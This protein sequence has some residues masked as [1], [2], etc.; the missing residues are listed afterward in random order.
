MVTVPKS[1]LSKPAIIRKRVVLPHP[2]GPRREKNSPFFI[3][4]LTLFKALKSPKDLDTPSMT[5]SLPFNLFLP[6]SLHITAYCR[7]TPI[8]S[9]YYILKGTMRILT[10]V[11][12]RFFKKT[13][14]K[15][16]FVK[17]QEG[18]PWYSTVKSLLLASEG[19]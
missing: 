17:Y 6:A 10:G 2:E 16:G 1:G 3:S 7:S 19:P 8:P 18:A 4:R 12:N 9:Q 14:K 11:V 13:H 5:T 15:P